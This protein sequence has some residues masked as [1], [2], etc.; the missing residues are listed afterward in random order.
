MEM[1]YSERVIS[2][3]DH[4]LR[5]GEVAFDNYYGISYFDFLR[6]NEKVG[7]IFDKSMSEMAIACHY[8][9]LVTEYDYSPF[10][11]IVDIGGGN[12]HFLISILEKTPNAKGTLFDVESC[13]EAARMKISSSSVSDRC[14]TVAGS[15]FDVI[16]ANADCYILQRILHDWDDE[17]ALKILLN[18]K[19]QM[20][21]GSKLL[22]IEEVICNQG[23]NV[24]KLYDI[25][26][27]AYFGGKT[28]TMEEI[29]QLFSKANLKLE[30]SKEIKQCDMFIMQFTSV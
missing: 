22:F 6:K 30:R 25:I 9:L 17:N 11:H 8:D 3:L 19:K 12:G 15:F 29:K 23:S 5:T 14:T 24:N 21:V 7:K 1:E 20:K 26:M 28:R 27:L 16:P 13:I 18:V 10:N 2:K 4:T